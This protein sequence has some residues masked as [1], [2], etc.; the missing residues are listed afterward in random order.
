MSRHHFK[1]ISY[2]LTQIIS[3]QIAFTA[4]RVCVCGI[5]QKFLYKS[6]H[7]GNVT[8]NF[9]MNDTLWASTSALVS[10]AYSQK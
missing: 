6:E 8:P 4:Q 7:F 5:V 3:L 1:A 10:E 9:G 2:Y